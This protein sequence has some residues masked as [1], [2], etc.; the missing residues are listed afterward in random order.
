VAAS[1]RATCHADISMMSAHEVSR[2]RHH[3]DISVDLVNTDQVNGQRVHVLTGH[4]GPGVSV[5]VTMIGGVHWSTG[6][7][8]KG[9]KGLSRY[10]AKS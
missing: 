4:L 6:L 8:E 1:G 3:H 10:W 5:S 2:C 7:K 9:K